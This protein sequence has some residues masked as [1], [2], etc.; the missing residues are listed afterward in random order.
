SAQGKYKGRVH[1]LKPDQ[2]EALRQ[3]WKEGKYPSKMAL[4]KAF[5]ISRQAVYRYLQVSE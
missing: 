1:K 5:G 2:A 3:A 4:G